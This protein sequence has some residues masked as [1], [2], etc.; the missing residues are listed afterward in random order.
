MVIFTAK[1]QKSKLIG[2]V[3]AAAVIVLLIVLLAN[4]G[5]AGA[6]QETF[7]RSGI[8]LETREDQIAFLAEQGLTA[9]AEPK[10]VQE[11]RIPKEWNEV[12]TAYNSIQ[13]AQGLDLSK[14][15]GKTVTQVV[16]PVTGYADDGDEEP[17]YATL[18]LYR[19]RLI[20]A[21]LSRGG[22]NG[23]LRP[24]ISA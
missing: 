2:I 19:N 6:L 1:L 4:R 23:F 16:Y 7:G 11:V 15:K 3:C 14:C 5:Q 20:G 9:E 18:L 21:D 12:Y 10:S 22:V 17:V 13:K 24:L 8:R